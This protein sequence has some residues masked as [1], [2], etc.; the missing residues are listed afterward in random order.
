M[1]GGADVEVIN[2]LLQRTSRTF[3]LAIPLLPSPTREEVTLAYLVFRIADTLEDG[4]NLPCSERRRALLEFADLLADPDALN[5]RR[6]AD[7][8]TATGPSDDPHYMELLAE[9]PRVL[10]VLADQDPAAQQAIRHHARRSAIGMHDMLNDDRAGKVH[11]LENLAQLRQYCYYVAGIVGELLTSLFEIRL[12]NGSHKNLAEHA[13][14]F[15]EGLQLVNILK[16][17][18]QDAQ[19]GRFFLPPSVDPDVVFQV[20]REDLGRARTYVDTLQQ[21]GAAPG[22]VAFA[23][24]PLRLAHLTLDCVERQGPGAKVPRN[25]VFRVLRGVFADCQL[26]PTST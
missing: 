15:G 12:V 16:D 13:A 7:C 6:F 11:H 18:Q 3:A 2:S 23:L 22:V 26:D 24:L 1:N 8:W 25:E 5:A 17:Q 21:V 4:E 14:A 19:R 20:A 9:T 10:E